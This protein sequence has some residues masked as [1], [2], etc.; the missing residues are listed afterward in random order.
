MG[1]IGVQAGGGEEAASSPPPRNFGQLK[2]F[3]QQDKFGQ[4]QFLKKFPCFFFIRRDRYFLKL[5]W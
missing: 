5:A 1:N 3:R 2:F 4:S